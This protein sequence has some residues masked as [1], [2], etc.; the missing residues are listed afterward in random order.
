MLRRHDTSAVAVGALRCGVNSLDKTRRAQ[1]HFA[2]A[3]NF[4]NVYANGNNHKRSRINRR[5]LLL[6]RN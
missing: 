4:D 1:E 3:R 2:N 5:R 6:A